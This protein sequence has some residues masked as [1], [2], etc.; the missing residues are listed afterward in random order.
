MLVGVL[1]KV[2]PEFDALVRVSDDKSKVE[3][4]PKYTINF[5]DLLALEEALKIKERFGGTV[6]VFSFC[7]AEMVE[8]LR[9]AI[10]MGADE[11]VAITFDGIE[12]FDNYCRAKLLAE[13]IKKEPFD[14]LWCGRE[15]FDEM[16]GVT[17]AMIAEIL[18]YPVVTLVTK[19]EIFP[20]EKKVLVE[21]ETDRGKEILKVA[22]PVLL[23][24]QKGLNEPRV[25]TV[26]GLMKAMKAKINTVELPVLLQ[27]LGTELERM[28]KMKPISY[29]PI[30]SSR[31]RKLLKGE[32]VE[33]V[34]ELI[35]L[36]KTEAKVI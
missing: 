29:V 25:P 21:R 11:V 10:A 9:S 22:M 23:S 30:I 24:A 6:K 8:T 31:K 33:V 3:V 36:L 7:R 2:V 14:L 16:E 32:P 19:V 28:I 1:A 18:G 20:Q 13:V 34:K 15:T 26:M 4:E 27:E 5:F 12:I 17:G 35:N